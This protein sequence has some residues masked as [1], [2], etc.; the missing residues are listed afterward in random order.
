MWYPLLAS[1]VLFTA[2]PVSAQSHY[3]RN[4]ASSD[5]RE[6]DQQPSN[7]SSSTRTRIGNTA[8]T[9]NGEVGQRQTREAAPN[10][11]PLGR[12]DSRIANRVQSRIRNRIDRTYDP[13]ANATSPFE[14]AGEQ[15]KAAGR[16]RR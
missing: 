2:A 9:G 1:V 15:T 7:P 3:D 16:P 4:L 6:D 11:K 13:Q 12:I 8:D 10:V 5:A 14:I